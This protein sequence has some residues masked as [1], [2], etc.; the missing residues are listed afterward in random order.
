MGNGLEAAKLFISTRC[1][2]YRSA[3]RIVRTLGV[4]AGTHK[5]VDTLLGWADD[6]YH[7]EI[8]QDMEDTATLYDKGVR[9]A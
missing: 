9:N 5:L 1:D 7:R 4:E 8:F 6:A 2:I 3:E